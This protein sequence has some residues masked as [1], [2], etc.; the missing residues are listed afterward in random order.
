[1]SFFNSSPVTIQAEPPMLGEG[2]PR[3]AMVVYR[4]LMGQPHYLLIGTRRRNDRLTLPGGKIDTDESAIETAIRETI[5]EAGVFTDQHRV[6]DTYAHHKASGRIH[7]TQTFLARYAG[8]GHGHEARKLYWLTLAELNALP[9]DIRQ[10]IRQQIER[11]A[12]VL[13]TLFAAA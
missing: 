5:E 9:Q 10:P 1:M 12:D 13:P 4:H 11:A 6:L 2:C 8:Y 7:P 3:A